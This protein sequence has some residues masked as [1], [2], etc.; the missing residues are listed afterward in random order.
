MDFRGAREIRRIATRGTAEINEDNNPE[1]GREPGLRPMAIHPGANLV[2]ARALTVGD[3][4]QG[5]PHRALKAYAGAVAAQS[6]IADDQGTHAPGLVPTK[7]RPRS[8]RPACHRIHHKIVYY[9]L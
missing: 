5:I 3:F 7:R 4:V 9:L 2:D 8:G 6:K 1:A